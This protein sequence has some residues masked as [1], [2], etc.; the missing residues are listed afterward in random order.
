MKTVLLIDDNREFR[1]IVSDWLKEHEWNVLEA[2]DGEIGLQLA[3]RHH[4]HAILCDLLMPRCNGFQFC[5]TFRSQEEHADGT[6]IIVTT[7]SG[8]ATDRM[9]ALEAGADE[10]LVK[11]INFTNLARVLDR[12]TDGGTTFRPAQVVT[13]DK[14]TKVKFWGVRGSIAAPGE[15]TVFYGGNTSCIEVR[16]NNEIIILDAGTGIRPLGLSLDKEFKNRPVDINILI[17]HTHWDHIQGFPFFMPAYNSQNRITIYGFEGARRG[18]QATLSSQMESPYFPISMQQMPGHVAIE[19]L[20]DLEFK[21]NSVPVR[22]H[23]LNHPGVCMGYRLQTDAGDVCYLPDVELFQRLRAEMEKES[24]V[25]SKEDREFAHEQDTKLLE[26]IKD[27]E[28]L[29]L[30]SQYDAAEYPSH[31]G[32][33]HSC[34]EDSVAFA[35]K[36]NAK[37]LFLFHHDPDHTDEHV[38]RMVAR[39]RQMVAHHQSSLVVEAAREGCEVVLDKLL[40]A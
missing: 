40:N 13:T 22:A 30:D 37:R 33:G 32:W 14:R 24:R 5:R 25:V 11:P 18:L 9:N 39:A 2:D 36:A 23:F 8:Y 35:I 16:V 27:C 4:P 28:V 3:L 6:A 29:I 15:S 1:G 31:V 17:T 21:I 19:E 12:F 20:R 34:M 38:S 26:F 7:G 10:Y